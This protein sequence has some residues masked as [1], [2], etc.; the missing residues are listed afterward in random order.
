MKRSPC[1]SHF[2]QEG[3]LQTCKVA[4]PAVAQTIPFLPEAKPLA[5][6]KE[7]RVGVSGTGLKL[8]DSL[9]P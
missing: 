6:S 5:G 3:V 9:A 1:N 2:D 7:E 4:H 8:A